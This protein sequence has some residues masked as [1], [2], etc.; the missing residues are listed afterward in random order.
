MDAGH[1]E[2]PPGCE[3]EKDNKTG[4]L[5]DPDRDQIRI[6][7]KDPQSAGDSK[8]LFSSNLQAGLW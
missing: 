1:I 7:G 3:D 2:D 8:I 6:C 5:R 4:L